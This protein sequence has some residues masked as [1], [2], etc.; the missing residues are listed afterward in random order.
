MGMDKVWCSSSPLAATGSYT[1]VITRFTRKFHPLPGLF[2]SSFERARR[3]PELTPFPSPKILIMKKYLVFTL[4]VAAMFIAASACAARE[5]WN[6]VESPN[7]VLVGNADLGEMKKLASKLE[8]FRLTLTTL[9]PNL[10]VT[11]PVPTRMYVFRT[12]DDFRP[13]KPMYQGKTQNNVAAYFAPTPNLNYIALSTDDD[14]ENP[15]GPVFHE[16]EHS[17]VRA[18]LGSVPLWLNEG[19]AELYSS[20]TL[21]DGNGRAVIG[22]PL[23][24]RVQ[25]LRGA[26]ILPLKTLFAVDHDSPDYNESSR[27]G[28]F[29]AE[30]WALVHYLVFQDASNN[31]RQ[32]SEFIANLSSD[33]TVEEAF[34]K[35]FKRDYKT[36]EGELRKYVEKFLFPVMYANFKEQIPDLKNLTG[37]K[38]SEAETEYFAG[39]LDFQVGR[40]E[41]AEK[42]LTRALTLD[43]KLAAAHISLGSLRWRQGRIDEAK[44]AYRTAVT[45]DPQNYLG[46][47]YDSIF[48]AAEGSVDEAIAGFRKALELQPNAVAVHTRLADLY[49][50][51]GKD[52]AALLEYQAALALDSKNGENQRAITY[53]HL[54]AGRGANAAL[55]AR[56]FLRLRGWDDERAAYVA[57]AGAIGYRN[58]HQNERANVLLQAA[59]RRL[60][61]SAWP[62]PIFRYLRRE[63]SAT[64]LLALATD[65]DKQTEAHA[66]LGLDLVQAGKP[67][68][69]R[70]HLEWV[71]THGNKGFI[72]YSLSRAELQRLN[73]VLSNPTQ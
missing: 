6:K 22:S 34:L 52:D 48:L 10:K 42:H 50:R 25:T 37:A 31:T 38:V 29:Y 23:T 20:F 56:A 43:P 30:S 54:R 73:T 65:K 53:I 66:Y 8:Q 55:A 1:R 35:A 70:E 24:S 61:A 4:A 2:R 33:L 14:Y 21:E 47:Y 32:L 67:D 27:A 36:V 69:A 5:Q 39:D 64:D 40:L 9:F 71:V 19:L 63:L 12:D 72:E 11:T 18:N 62:A 41:D 51:L 59:G 26:P 7:F 15:L 3:F 49:V 58:S 17:I 44:Q 45:V 60:S 16:Y 68:E 57:L 46:Y 28:I 13:F